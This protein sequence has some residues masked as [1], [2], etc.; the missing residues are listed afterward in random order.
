M[1]VLEI[2]GTHVTAAIVETGGWTVGAAQRL[3]LDSKADADAILATMARAGSALDGVEGRPWGVAMPDPF[4][5][6]T[7]IGR[8]HGVGKFE[9]LDGVDVRS[10][11]ARS[12]PD[13]ERIAF[14]NDADAFSVGE[15]QHGAG[16]SYARCVGLT[17]GTGV[18]SGWVVDGRAVAGGPGV[19]PG[20]RIHLVEAHGRPLEDTMS[21]RAI[22][23]AY[24]ADTGDG[25][26][27]VREI[28]D[29]ARAGQPA[30]LDVLTH[31]LCRLGE[32]IGPRLREFG[33][34][35]LVIGGSMSGSWDL[36]EPWLRAGM[37]GVAV[38]IAVSADTERAA[39]LGAAQVALLA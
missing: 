27:D 29:R 4:D 18:G 24:A 20:G 13:P 25:D 23:R 30:A 11:L 35:V 19:P 33:A 38:P 17:L 5:Y 37:A 3:A 8:F 2:G 15:A 12:L 34:D 6:A 10:A 16:A 9:S 39:L 14:T 31:A 21:R 22:R 36:F 1:P 26:A 7:G 32:V 28:A